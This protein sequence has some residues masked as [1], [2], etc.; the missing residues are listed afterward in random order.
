VYKN[1]E[2]IEIVKKKSKNK[3]ILILVYYRQRD[4]KSLNYQTGVGYS[5][6]ILNAK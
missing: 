4:H 6:G 3:K 5:L 2:S 1:E